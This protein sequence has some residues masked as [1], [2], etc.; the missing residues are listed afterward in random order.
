MLLLMCTTPLFDS[1]S[2]VTWLWNPQP[3]LPPTP[4]RVYGILFDRNAMERMSRE[5]E[6]TFSNGLGNLCVRS[7]RPFSCDGF[8][9]TQ[10]SFLDQ[11][12]CLTQYISHFPLWLNCFFKGYSG[13]MQSW[14]VILQ[15]FF[16]FV[17]NMRYTLNGQTVK[18]GMHKAVRHTTRRQTEAIWGPA[19]WKPSFYLFLAFLPDLASV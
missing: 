1:F 10:V 4:P 19:G 6:S 14:R 9:I 11:E 2:P 7:L 15:D 8:L 18:S 13:F 12:S 5:E 16:F 17:N 3:H